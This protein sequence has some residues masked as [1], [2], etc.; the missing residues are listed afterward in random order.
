MKNVGCAVCA[1]NTQHCPS[2]PRR[3]NRP[4]G[5]DRKHHGD[6]SVALVKYEGTRQNVIGG[7]N[8]DKDP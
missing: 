7:N 2:E 8:D 4:T 6:N 3:H 5:I 1:L